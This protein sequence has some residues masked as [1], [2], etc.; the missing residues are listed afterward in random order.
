[1]TTQAEMRRRIL[2]QRKVVLAKHTRK[3]QTYDELP[4]PFVKTRAMK[5][6]ELKF[7]KPLK[8]I[9]LTSETI[10]QL[11][12]KT[13]MDRTTISRWRKMLNKIFWKEFEK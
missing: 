7:G 9:I 1:M 8:D 4:S 10:D 11:E 5:Y 2:G 6:L 13:G 12:K 3:I